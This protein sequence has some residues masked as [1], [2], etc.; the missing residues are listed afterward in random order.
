MDWDP[1]LG[2]VSPIVLKNH[3]S[4]L[5]E[6]GFVTSAIADG[7]VARTMRVCARSA[8]VC[9]LPLGV[10]AWARDV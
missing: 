1:A 7:V 10:A 9:I 2:E 8:L 4:A 3:T 6:S 5:A